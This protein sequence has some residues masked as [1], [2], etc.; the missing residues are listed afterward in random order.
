MNEVARDSLFH[1][2]VQF[3]CLLDL[4]QFLFD[5]LLNIARG[6][7]VSAINFCTRY[8]LARYLLIPRQTNI[9][10][11]NKVYAKR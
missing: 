3:P 4:N 8:L 10:N 6:Q 9:I 5:V 7:L 2:L 11:I 1:F